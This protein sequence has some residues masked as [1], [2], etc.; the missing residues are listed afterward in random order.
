[1]LQSRSNI[2]SLP[3]L[4]HALHARYPWM[5]SVDS[6]LPVPKNSAAVFAAFSLVMLY[7][8]ISTP[9]FWLLSSSICF[10][11]FSFMASSS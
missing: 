8:S 6:Y 9:Y 5:C 4:S 11:V 7:I 3:W 1:M 10:I 2:H